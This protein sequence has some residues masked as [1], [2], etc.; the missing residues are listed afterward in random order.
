MKR[1]AYVPTFLV[2]SCSAALGFV[3]CGGSE[4]SGGGAGGTAAVGGGATGGKGTTNTTGGTVSNG[5]GESATGGATVAATGGTTAAGGA[6][7]T[8]GAAMGG[9]G[10]L[11]IQEACDKECAVMATRSPPLDCVP[12]DCLTTCNSSYTKLYA[13]NPDCGNDYL[14][15]L[16]CGVTQPADSWYCFTVSAGTMVIS[17]PVPPSKLSTDPCYAEFQKLYFTM[18]SNL[19][20]CGT[21][22]SQ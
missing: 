4:D 11:D 19:T 13:A 10:A 8:G 22:L 5:G 12:A 2:A 9:T 21:A 16:R 18:L 15:M 14:G 20:T 3:S 6:S 17:I 7:S 1:A